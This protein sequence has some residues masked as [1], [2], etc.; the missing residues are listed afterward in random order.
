MRQIRKNTFETNSSST[1]SITLCDKDCGYD[2]CIDNGQDYERT[3]HIDL[4]RYGWE[5]KWISSPYE[6]LQY[7]LTQIAQTLCC[8]E[9]YMSEEDNRDEAREEIYNNHDFE[10]ILYYVKKNTDFDT[11]EIG[12]LDGHIEHGSYVN[13]LYELCDEAGCDSIE[14]F[15]F[16]PSIKIRQGNDNEWDPELYKECL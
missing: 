8:I 5:W 10:T 15:L 14:D 7:V 16:N 9:D 6:K 2:T 13:T 3:L 11:I 4:A 12:D 1:H